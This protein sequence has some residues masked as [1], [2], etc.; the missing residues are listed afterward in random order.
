MLISLLL[1][2]VFAFILTP[3][4]NLELFSQRPNTV[5]S[6][7]IKV[8]NLCFVFENCI[9]M[10]IS[11]GVVPAKGQPIFGVSLDELVNRPENNNGNLNPDD[12]REIPKIIDDAIK[13]L[14]E[15]GTLLMP[16]KK[17]NLILQKSND[18]RG[19]FPI[20]LWQFTAERT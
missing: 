1:L 3:F 19:D 10:L 7:C 14:R 13:Y 5:A 12:P 11:F 8:C 6:L 15:R 4:R 17:E 2:V 18:S 20:I 16:K 9:F